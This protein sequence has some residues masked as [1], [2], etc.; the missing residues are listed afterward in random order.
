VARA[1]QHGYSVRAFSRSADR[2]SIDDANLETISGDALRR[3]DVERALDQVDVA[4]QALGVATGPQI[5]LGGVTLFSESTRLLVSAMEAAGVNRLISVTGFGAGDSRPHLNCIE[6][7]PF[8][9]LLGRAYDDKDTQ[10]QLIRDSTLDWT[11]VRPVILTNG[12]R[13]GQ[14]E[15][16]ID[17]GQWRNGLISRADVA[18]FLVRQIDDDGYVGETPVLRNS[19]RNS[20]CAMMDRRYPELT[21]R[22]S[23]H[24][25]SI[26]VKQ[27]AS[28]P[29]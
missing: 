5:V 11:I 22:A 28:V 3:D 10:E 13:S 20:L 14:Y 4:I 15:A 16:Y 21:C 17:A 12:P 19:T 26:S 8:E 25:K 2:I 29:E 6:R 7:I 24:R 27:P 1:L 18:D 9:L 23:V